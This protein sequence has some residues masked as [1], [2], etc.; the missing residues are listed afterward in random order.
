MET[1][2][3]FAEV[4][5]DY[6]NTEGFWT[7]DAWKTSDDNEEGTVIAAIH[8]TTGDVFYADALARISP[9]AQA[10]ITAKVQEIK[11]SQVKA[12][13]LFGKAAVRAYYDSM[14]QTSEE[15]R[16]AALRDV[17][18]AGYA[19]TEKAFSS[20]KEKTAYYSGMAEADGWEDYCAVSKEDYDTLT[21]MQEEDDEQ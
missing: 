10:V 21:A 19:L 20:E 17:M 11:S 7:V 5:C 6:N 18:E 16:K 1:K 3:F 2:E 8:E 15:S 13:T 12:Y 9:K 4:K 14:A